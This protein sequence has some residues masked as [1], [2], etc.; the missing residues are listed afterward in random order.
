MAVDDVKDDD[1]E[2][3]DESWTFVAVTTP[4]GDNTIC[5]TTKC[6]VG[7]GMLMVGGCIT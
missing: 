3:A 2:E 4:C 1:E 6:G 7:S 5:G